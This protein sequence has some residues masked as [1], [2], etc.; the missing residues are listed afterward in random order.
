[1]IQTTITARDML[2]R[3]IDDTERSAIRMRDMSRFCKAEAQKLEEQVL[4]LRNLLPPEPE[5]AAR[6]RKTK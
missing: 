6:K 2:L 3:C 5:P 1:M 4:R